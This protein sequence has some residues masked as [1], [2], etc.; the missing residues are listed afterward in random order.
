MTK[1][2]VRLALAALFL[3]V[4]AWPASAQTY[5]GR[6]DVTVV[7]ST[8]AVLPGVTVDLTGPQAASA[9]TDRN[10]E[11][12]FL[13]LAPGTYAVGAKLQGFG[14]YSNK[15]V[16][17]ST[18]VSVPLKVTMSPGGVSAK[19]S[20]EAAATPLVDTRKETVTTN[21]NLDELQNIPSSRDPWVVL[22]TVPGVIVDRVNVGGAESGQQSTY[23]AKG[24]AGG[25][26]T[27]NMDG[28]PI[29]DMSALGSTPT[30]YDFDMFQEMNV[31]T[32]GSDL[33]IATPGVA[34]NFV[35]RS[36]TNQWRGSGR[37][38]VE[39]HNLESNNVSGSIAG[40]VSSYNRIQSLYDYGGE[41]GGPIVMNKLFIQASAG[42]THPR[43]NIFTCGSTCGGS[44]PTYSITSHD[45]TILQDYSAK[46]TAEASKNV[47]LSFTFFDGNKV[48]HGRGASGTRPSATTDDQTGPTRLYKGEA[49]LTL[50][51]SAFLTARYAYLTGGFALT[52]EGGLST[53]AYRDDS[54][55]WHGSYYIYSTNRPQN[56]FSADGNWFK[57]KSELKYGFGYRKATV[58]SDSAWPGGGVI[59]F[60]DTYPNMDAEIVR[61]H[62]TNT[63]AI[64]ANAYIGDTMT[65]DRVTANMGVRWDRQAA[66][67]GV[68]A[69]P[70]NSADPQNFLPALTG[71]AQSSAVVWQS[72]SPRAGL[73]YALDKDRRTIL[74]ASYAM[75]ASQLNATQASVLSTVQYSYT[76]YINVTDANGNGIADA[77]EIAAAYAA[78]HGNFAG[79]T[80]F[81]TSNP[82]ALTTPNLIGQY[83]TP[84]TNEI[85]IGA[86]H[87]VARDVAVG[88]SYTYRRYFDYDWNHLQGVDGTQYTVGG[89]YTCTGTEVSV[90]GACSVPYYVINPAA[91]NPPGNVYEKRQG[92][93]QTFNGVEL[94]GTKRMSNNWQARAAFSW[95]SS[96]QYFD[97]RNAYG[98]P[99]PMPNAPNING[100]DVVVQTSG[101]GK[102][103]IYLVEPKYQFIYN[104]AYTTK[105]GINL[106]VNYLLRQGYA[107]PY[108]HS[109]VATGDAR[110]NKKSILLTSSVD[111]FRLPVMNSVDVRVGKTFKANKTNFDVDLDLFNVFNL[112]TVLGRQYDMRSAAANTILEVMNPRTIRIGFRAS[113]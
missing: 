90:V 14:D 66:S 105:Y 28:I 77:S 98:D 72:L 55:V 94:Y 112:N 87:Q 113:F 109:S 43:L 26:N 53:P 73:S 71:A 89:T 19:V 4:L 39:N 70:A 57:G 108:F 16:P 31:T 40:Q 100:G 64:Y 37:Y 102:S 99:T 44:S 92:Y 25:D 45:E 62:H 97:T 78:S 29:T 76:Y 54:L 8:G 27:W 24:A 36:G 10:G 59:T 1:G 93:R 51:N 21:V 74:R 42:E 17:V 86:D 95:N 80:G 91:A 22:Q 18:G 47:R 67:L 60:Y 65:W 101:S 96:K 3:T 84:L 41:G 107:E 75:F 103:N 104:M 23:F 9:V 110:T 50:S 52:P 12:H 111:Q 106:G 83:V 85:V 15:N 2:L 49:N 34:L 69:D 6:I 7:D 68:V 38:F 58:T 46:A 88:A 30:Y 61:E 33:S 81:S 11:A 35:L 5:T 56:D 20:V 63:S 82:A 32:G 13:N 79:H 48:K